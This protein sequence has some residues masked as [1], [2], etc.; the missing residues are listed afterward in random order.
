MTGTGP[1][2]LQPQLVSDAGVVRRSQDQVKPLVAHRLK[3]MADAKVNRW[4]DAVQT[5]IELGQR[6]RRRIQVRR[7]HRLTASGRLDGNNP[8]AGPQI[9]QP[10]RLRPVEHRQ[11]RIRLRPD[12]L[13]VLDEPAQLH[14]V[15]AIPDGAHPMPPD[16]GLAVSLALGQSKVQKW[17]ACLRRQ[18][19]HPSVLAARRKQPRKAIFRFLHKPCKRRPQRHKLIGTG[20][21]PQL[22]RGLLRSLFRRWR[23][24]QGAAIRL[25]KS[26]QI[27][28]SPRQS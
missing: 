24:H 19:F 8:R 27:R 9:E 18:R 16:Q 7:H 17:P 22:G 2:D 10:S 20:G 11:Q 13:E 1:Q 26:I 15:K 3:L 28:R 21:Q 5:S 23:R 6:N 14:H 25:S 12:I 4:G